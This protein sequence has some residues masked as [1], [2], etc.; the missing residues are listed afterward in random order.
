MKRLAEESIK[1]RGLFFGLALAFCHAASPL[2]AGDP[3]V[4]SKDN[5]KIPPELDKSRDKDLLRSWSTLPRQ[6]PF[7]GYYPS[8][9]SAVSIDPKQ[10]KKWRNAQTERK[11]WLLLEP[12]ELQKLD[13]N[14]NFGIKEYSL[15]KKEDIQD[16]TFYNLGKP[17]TSDPNRAL[18]QSSKSTSGQTALG[19]NSHEEWDLD[20]TGDSLSSIS[21]S[22]DKEARDKKGQSR[23]KKEST[24]AKPFLPEKQ[25]N[26]LYGLDQ[27]DFT[28][29]SLF[30]TPGLLPEGHG[31]Q[32]RPGAFHRVLGPGQPASR[33]SS[34][35][36][37]GNTLLPDTTKPDIN[38][39]S[40]SPPSAPGGFFPPNQNSSGGDRLVPSA[41]PGLNSTRAPGLSADLSTAPARPAP[42]LN[43]IGQSP[44]T[45]P[46]RRSKF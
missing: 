34:L 31:N 35:A 9:G 26:S 15:D 45:G 8:S 28:L 10:Q 19:E 37:Q 36:P 24:W 16:Y 25:E 22:S 46:P 29:P 33:L 4:F 32:T 1:R 14:N 6:E 38:S 41:L 3:I 20:G 40:V 5:L 7:D 13:D 42:S 30:N 27:S 21:F 18:G 11:N 17:K 39:I 23:E 2:W 44:L 12:G 43:P